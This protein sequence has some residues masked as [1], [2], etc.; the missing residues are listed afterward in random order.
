MEEK[1]F[2]QMLAQVA[3]AYNTTPDAIYKK[4]SLA[5]E[6]GKQDPDHQALSLWQSIPRSGTDLTLEDFVAY[7]AQTL[8]RPFDP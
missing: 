1:S 7:L 4:I 8:P 3:I 5:I 2:A 6:E